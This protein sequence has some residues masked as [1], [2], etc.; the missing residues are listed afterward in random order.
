[1]KDTKQSDSQRKSNSPLCRSEQTSRLN[2]INYK[3]NY[4]CRLRFIP[5]NIS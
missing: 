2:S 4:A 3:E 5:P 1:M